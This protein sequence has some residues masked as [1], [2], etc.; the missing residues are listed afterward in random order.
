MALGV[1]LDNMALWTGIGLALG[2]VAGV[3]LGRRQR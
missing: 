2:T 1:V 3:T